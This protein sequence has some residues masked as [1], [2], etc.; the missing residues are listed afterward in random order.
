MT[1]IERLEVAKK[2]FQ[3]AGSALRAVALAPASFPLTQ[4]HLQLYLNLHLRD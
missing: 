4:G 3:L 2:Q 1:L